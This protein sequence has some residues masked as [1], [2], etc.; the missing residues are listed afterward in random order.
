MSEILQDFS[1]ASIVTAIEE[2]L[3]SWIPVF[4]KIW[5]SRVNDPPG[6]I[7]SI[8]DIPVPLFNSI[9]DARLT[10]DNVDAT[11]QSLLSDGTQRKVPLLWWVGPSTTPTDLASYLQKN[12]FA[13]D[14]D[15]PGMAVVLADLN[16]SLPMPGGLSIQPVQDDDA[17]REWCRTMAQGFEIPASKFELAVNSWHFLLSR[18]NPETTQAFIARLNGEAVATSMLQLGGGVAGIYAVATIPEARRQGIGFQVTSYALHQASSMGYTVGILQAS[19]MGLPVYRSLGFREY[20]R[21]TS[22][23]WRPNKS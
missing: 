12:G 11:I 16:E 7:R 22:Y 1:N 19:E 4:G 23:V 17:R 6:V 14:D 5:E 3:F 15:G 13:V 9:M 8:S 18:M 10:P 2:N 21:I 20:C